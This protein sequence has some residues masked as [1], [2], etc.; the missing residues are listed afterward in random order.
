MGNKP[1]KQQ[2]I[3][4]LVNWVVLATVLYMGLNAWDAYHGKFNTKYDFTPPTLSDDTFMAGLVKEHNLQYNVSLDHNIVLHTTSLS[5]QNPIDVEVRVFPS[6]KYRDNIPNQW[7]TMPDY[8][9]IVLPNAIVYDEPQKKWKTDLVVIT[10]NKQENP[11]QYYGKSTIK[12]LF[13]GEQGYFFM[14]PSEMD[15][16]T[17]NGQMYISSAYILN[18]TKKNPTFYIGG[19]DETI[20]L[21]QNN[22]FL[23]LTFV[24]IAF[25]LIE[26]RTHI[27][28]GFIWFFDNK[29]NKKQHTG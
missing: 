11:N 29:P 23:A 22:I 18:Q 6:A 13:E 5:A 15:K 10:L 1:T 19:S 2:T 12:Y 28:A 16:Y 26:A 3:S 14:I 21:Q 24:L 7:K 20:N 4:F 9:T 27:I 25:A 17:T 8:V